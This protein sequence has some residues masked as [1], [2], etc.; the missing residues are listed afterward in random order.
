MSSRKSHPEMPKKVMLLHNPTAGASHPNAEELL[1]SIHRTI[2]VKPNYFSTKKADWKEALSKRWDLV[3]LAGGDGTVGKS[4]RWLKQ[5][6]TPI[7]MLPLGTANN[8][9]RSLGI[10]GDLK[11]LLSTLTAGS[12][13]SLDVGYAKGPWGTRMFLEAVGVGSIAEGVSQSGPRPPQPIRIDM[14][15]DDLQEL[16]E[17]SEPELFE[18]EVDGKKFAGEFLFVEVLNLNF[19]G[20]ALPL[21]FHASPDDGLFDVVF[22]EARNRKRM[23]TWLGENPEDAPPPLAVLQGTKVDMVWHGGHLRIDSRVFLPPKKPA[24]ISIALEKQSFRVMVPLS[25]G[26]GEVTK[27]VSQGVS[28]RLE[29]KEKVEQKY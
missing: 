6:K 10:E 26:R 4:V 11:S 25:S 1:R 24:K 16:V 7:V 22:L 13:R 29:S 14:A 18:L 15:R 20:P 17:N 12:V 27:T 3:I 21:A 2:G 19:T 28:D 5:R 9:A 23:L 8:I